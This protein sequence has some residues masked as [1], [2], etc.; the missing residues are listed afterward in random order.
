MMRLSRRAS[1]VQGFIAGLSYGSAAIFIRLLPMMNPAS[2]AFWRLIIASAV[3]SVILVLLGWADRLV[4]L[5]KIWWRILPLGFF[6]GFHFIL[7]VMAV[8]NTSV[9]NA[10]V[11]VNTSPIFTLLLGC[12]FFRIKPSKFSIIGILIS[13]AG[14]IVLG[15]G[16]ASTGFYIHLLGDFQ[17]VL[18]A[19][20][21]GFYLNFGRDVRLRGNI[22]VLMIPIFLISALTVGLI[23]PLAGMGIEFCWDGIL[24]IICLGVIPTAVGHTLYFSSLAGLNSYETATLALLE[25]IGATILAAIIFGEIPHP[26][27]IF[28][29]LLILIGVWIVLLE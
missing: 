28:G 13:F 21:E 26:I 17:A 27:F 5:R 24:W 16:Y 18:A 20:S 2:I 12:L 4:V 1:I 25:P 14:I 9:L 10:T 15:L 29:G 3:L 19:F 6:L 8:K 22:L 11:L 7:F 23:S